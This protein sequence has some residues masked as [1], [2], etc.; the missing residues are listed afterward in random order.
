MVAGDYACNNLL[1]TAPALRV[2]GGHLVEHPFGVDFKWESLNEDEKQ[3]MRA[4][5]NE[6][7]PSA[8]LI[9]KSSEQANSDEYHHV[10]LAMAVNPNTPAPV[11]HQLAQSGIHHI[12]ERV[13]ENPRANHATLTLLSQHRH[14]D[15]RA[16][17]AKNANT[18]LEILRTLAA[19]ENPDVRYRL[20]E[21]HYT[22]TEILYSLV[23]DHNPY[24]ACRAQ[25]TLTRLQ[26][27][28][29]L[30]DSSWNFQSPIERGYAGG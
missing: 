22:P 19:D 1:L 3:A 30:S 12:L 5:L 14:H 21:N 23:E 25:K 11:L 16:A 15:V 29:L 18:P 6:L 27:D 9:T 24:V 17:V 7:S 10:R 2:G 26:T 20:A 4:H 28:N 8:E 13:A